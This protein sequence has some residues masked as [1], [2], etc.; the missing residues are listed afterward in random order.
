MLFFLKFNLG[1][2]PTLAN[3]ALGFLRKAGHCEV[4][5]SA[6]LFFVKPMAKGFIVHNKQKHQIFIPPSYPVSI[7]GK[8]IEN[9]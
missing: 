3:K 1:G 4:K 6:S 9:T 2:Y 5:S 8:N 7:I